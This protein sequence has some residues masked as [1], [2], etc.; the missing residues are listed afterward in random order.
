VALDR[1][2]LDARTAHGDLPALQRLVVAWATETFPARDINTVI[3]K[4]CMEE[5]PELTLAIG[6]KD[7]PAI[8]QEL[9][10][11]V[12][13]VL[14]LAEMLGIDVYADALA[15]MEVNIRREWTI[16]EDGV[17]RHVART[18][19]L[20]VLRAPPARW[21]PAPWVV[22]EEAGGLCVV[23]ATGRWVMGIAYDSTTRS[24]GEVRAVLEHVVTAVNAA[25]PDVSRRV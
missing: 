22:A 9:S 15:K 25:D 3:K 8:R 2:L 10:D 24:E 11:V 18:A 12:I 13:L 14:D 7:V 21:A 4:L 5:L 6:T 20:A 19:A 1:E 16:G 23:D 17:S